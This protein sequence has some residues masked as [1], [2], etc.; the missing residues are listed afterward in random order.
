MIDRLVVDRGWTWDAYRDW[1][2][3]TATH[4]LFA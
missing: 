1:V 3:E 4:A 2:A